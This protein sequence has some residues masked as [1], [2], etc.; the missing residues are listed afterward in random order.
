MIAPP[1]L[2]PK[3]LARLRDSIAYE[4]PDECWMWIGPMYGTEAPRFNYTIAGRRYC[5]TTRRI[6]FNELYGPVPPGTHVYTACR[7]R[8]CMNP[9]HFFLAP[10]GFHT[11]EEMTHAFFSLGKAREMRAMRKD[12]PKL[13]FEK[14]GE[15]WGI[16]KTEAFNVCHNKIWTEH[17]WPYR[18]LALTQTT[19]D[20]STS[21]E[22]RKPNDKVG[23]ETSSISQ[24]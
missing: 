5:L 17:R 19:S 24:G 16:S 14:L 23:P 20:V 15:M 21:S 7:N 6:L 18:N 1:R 2:G 12:N 3:A 10:Q 13:S 9:E 8:V 4:G 22:N 11:G